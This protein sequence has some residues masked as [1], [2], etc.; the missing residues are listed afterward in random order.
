V[1]TFL[2]AFVLTSFCNAAPPDSQ[3]K[4][5]GPAGEL[6]SAPAN[7]VIPSKEPQRKPVTVGEVIK[8]LGLDET[9]IGYSDEPPGKLAGVYWY[10]VKLPGTE[11]EVDVEIQLAT[12]GPF[13][14]KRAWDI[15]QVRA[16]TV[17]KVE[18]T[19]VIHRE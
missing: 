17:R 2:T 12:R 11:A 9:K 4:P 1:L 5:A 18:I 19:S 13:S 14:E 6:K 7:R 8:S 15:K 16:A 10:N 3:P